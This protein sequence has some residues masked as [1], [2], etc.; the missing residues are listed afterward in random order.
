MKASDVSSPPGDV[1]TNGPS[2]AVLFVDDDSGMRD[3]GV[4]VLEPLQVRIVVAGSAVQALEI[5]SRRPVD[6]IISDFRM[7]RISGLEFL[8][9]VRA[10]KPHVPFVMMSAH[11]CMDTV[12][13][14]LRLGAADFLV[15][16]FD[17]E[18]LRQVVDRLLPRTEPA[19][20][21]E[22]SGAF[23][24][25]GDADE[26][27]GHA[28]PGGLL[29]QSPAFLKCLDNARRVASTRSTVLITGESGTGKEGFARLIHESSPRSAGPFIPV[30]CGALP[31]NLIESELFGHVRGAFTGAWADRPG[32][33][34]L[35][36][37]GT[38]FLDEIGEMP[39]NMQVR[40]LRALQEQA[41]EPVGGRSV[42]TDFRL[43]A[44][45]NRD[46]REEV[47]AGRFREDLWY[48]LHVIPLALPPLREREEDVILLAK[49]FLGLLNARYRTSLILTAENERTLRGHTWP[50]NVRELANTME[51]A[52]VLAEGG[53]IR[54][55]LHQP[56]GRESGACSAPEA[57][58]RGSRQA[59]EREAI[60]AALESCRWNKT[61]AAQRLAIS[62]RGLLYKVKQ[63]RI[64]KKWPL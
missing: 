63:Y 60:L 26:T 29:G 30:N 17:N 34:V 31:E 25:P 53:R 10:V 51:R 8:R 40:L 22:P 38:L 7:P 36:H 4:A 32:K 2:P 59:A 54:I 44:A 45:T 5:L 33:F 46:L 37:G 28:P 18:A 23:R 15:K 57:S 1:G 48:R 62:R 55:E 41:V 50:G 49:H 20:P 56:R 3:L 61:L 19:G 27:T 43:I 12:I 21:F 42:R 9:R 24:T 39:L 11:G 64:E 6:V 47:A 52:V 14:A 13:Q 35:A 58:V 16:P